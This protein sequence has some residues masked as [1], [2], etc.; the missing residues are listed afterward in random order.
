MKSH[1]K[2]AVAS[3]NI[4]NEFSYTLDL[5]NTE[6]SRIYHRT[7]CD[8]LSVEVDACYLRIDDYENR[9]KVQNV[10]DAESENVQPL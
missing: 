1:Y 3:I 7:L 6:V 5:F 2:K 4:P 9:P 10:L 8:S